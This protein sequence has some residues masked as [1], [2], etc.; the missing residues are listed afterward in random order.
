MPVYEYKCKKCEESFEMQRKFSDPPLTECPS[1]GMGPV[2]KLVSLNS[3]KLKG[4]GWYKS[5]YAGKAPKADSACAGAGSKPSCCGCP[6]A[7][8]E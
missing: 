5:D 2:E 3:F 4:S 6:G 8:A 7:S 1:C